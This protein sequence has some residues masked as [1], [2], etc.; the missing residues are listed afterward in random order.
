MHLQI[1]EKAN[2]IIHILQDAGYEAY[3]VGGCVRDALLGR[4]AA[5]WD[6]T[7]SALPEQVKGLFRRTLDTGLQHGTVTVMLEREGFEVTTYRID[8][9]YE[10]GRHPRQVQ[11]TPSLSEDL[12]RRDFTINAMAYNDREGLVDLFGGRE[13][14]EGGVIRCVGDPTERFSEDALRILRAVRFGA[15]LGFSIQK[16]TRQAMETLA[17]NLRKISAERIQ[18]ELTK[19][20]VSPH[21]EILGVAYEAGITAVILPEFDRCMETEQNTPYHCY[22]VGE[23]TLH[24]LTQIRPDKVLRLTMLLHDMGKPGS[25][26][27]DERGVDHFYG[28]GLAGE[29]LAERIL[30]RLRFD[31]ETIR[32]VRRLVLCHDDR[33]ENPTARWVR[34]AVFRIGEDL[35]P[36]YLEVRRA[37][38]LAQN[39]AFREKSLKNLEQVEALYRNILEEKNCVSLK[40]LAVTGHDLIEAG[41]EPGKPVGETLNRLLELVMDHPEYNKKEYLLEQIKRV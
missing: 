33:Q 29:K 11:F 24:A 10:D 13:D 16:E 19:I 39:P 4:E 20:L 34:R 31:N 28:H 30:R 27:K 32:Q 8:G 2:E 3:V 5:D 41:V 23:H 12:R 22:N 36:Y 1:P 21:P 9:E 18:A 40:G 6:I 37:D 38:I 17:G 14:L 7:T 35:F 25:R 26:I 15:Q